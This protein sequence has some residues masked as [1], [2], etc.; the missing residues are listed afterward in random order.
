[1]VNFCEQL[2]GLSYLLTARLHDNR[3]LGGKNLHTL[4]L[5][6]GSQH[7]NR[8]LQLSP[9]DKVRWKKSFGNARPSHLAT[10]VW[11]KHGHSFFSG[12]LRSLLI[13]LLRP[14]Q[15][16]QRHCNDKCENTSFAHSVSFQLRI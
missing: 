2:F 3:A 16:W 7:V 14:D 10:N 6:D 12:F 13:R 1:M 4:N 15:C 9:V 5:H 8:I 11:W